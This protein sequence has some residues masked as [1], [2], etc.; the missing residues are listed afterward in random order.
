MRGS[1]GHYEGARA[2]R[3]CL[4]VVICLAAG[5]G[6]NFKESRRVTPGGF[7]VRTRGVLYAADERVADFAE[8]EPFRF[9]LQNRL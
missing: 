3:Q 8:R 6:V 4:S 1:Y 9:V 7:G 2:G 5:S